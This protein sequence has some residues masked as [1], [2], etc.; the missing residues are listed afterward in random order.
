M[1]KAKVD[2]REITVPVNGKE[3]TLSEEKLIEIIECYFRGEKVRTTLEIALTPTEGKCFEV[4]FFSIDQ[5][6]FKRKRKNP[7]QEHL[8][9]EI[10]NAFA[11]V[12]KNPERYAIP[13]KTVIPQRPCRGALPKLPE[14]V[15]EFADCIG[16]HNADWVEQTLEWA[17]RISNGE[18]WRTLCNKNDTAKWHRLVEGANGEFLCV[19]GATEDI[20]TGKRNCINMS[21]LAPSR[22]VEKIVPLVVVY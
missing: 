9:K 16:D 13:F 4:N 6:K 15:K 14:E 22:Y 11:E 21:L 7:V 20:N 2:V 3:V 1:I 17:Q 8:R 19:G 12:E 18:N 10:L 5:N